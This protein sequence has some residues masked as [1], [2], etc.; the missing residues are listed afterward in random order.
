[1]KFEV[2]MVWREPKRCHADCYFCMVSTKGFNS[3]TK[4]AASHPDIPSARRPVD[5][6]AS[7]H[8]RI[9]DSPIVYSDPAVD[10][11]DMVTGLFSL[12]HGTVTI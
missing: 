4:H 9:F 3:K 10:E 2:P 11:D 6:C 5:Y 7:T 12:P 1:M 8:F